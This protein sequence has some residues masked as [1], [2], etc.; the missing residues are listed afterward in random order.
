MLLHQAKESWDQLS[1]F[2]KNATVASTILS[3]ANGMT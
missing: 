1:D 2:R 3:G